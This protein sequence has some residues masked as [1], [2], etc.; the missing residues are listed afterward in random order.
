MASYFIQPLR[1]RHSTQ[2]NPSKKAKA[3]N[4]S[5]AAFAKCQVLNA[6]F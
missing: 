4:F 5:L 1:S 2:T 3:A 6:D